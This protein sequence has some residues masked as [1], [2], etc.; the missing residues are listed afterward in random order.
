M[1]EQTAETYPADFHEEIETTDDLPMPDPHDHLACDW[2]NP[3][4]CADDN[5]LRAEL[6]ALAVRAYAERTGV[7][8]EEP[9]LAISDL[10]GDLMHLCDALGLDFQGLVDRGAYH[11]EPELRGEF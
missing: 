8:G 1:T 11:Y 6:A 5:T 3:E 7:L 10:L 4:A 2:G 9:A